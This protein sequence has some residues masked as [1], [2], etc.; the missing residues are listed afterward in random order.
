MNPLTR[1]LVVAFTLFELGFEFVA[2]FP[3][4][5]EVEHQILDIEPQLREGVL[6]ED[7]NPLTA[8]EAVDDLGIGVDEAVVVGVLQSR[9]S[10]AEFEQLAGHIVWFGGKTRAGGHT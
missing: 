7:E 6:N 2:F 1:T 8:L 3:G 5:I 4:G 9:N 10:P